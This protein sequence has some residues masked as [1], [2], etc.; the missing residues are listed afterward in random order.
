MV[1][2]RRQ[3]VNEAE[4]TPQF[5]KI[6]LSPH[7]SKL[8]IPDEFVMKYG[9]NMR[10]LVALEVPSGAIWK[11]KLQNSNGMAWL[12]EGWDQFKE[13]YSIGCGYF[14]LFQYNGISHFSVS[15]F[16]LSASEIEYP[17]G[18][19][20]DMTPENFVKIVGDASHRKKEGG[21]ETNNNACDDI[22]DD[23]LRKKTAKVTKVADHSYS[24]RQKSSV[25]EWQDR[26][27]VSL[28]KPHVEEDLYCATEKE[29]RKEIK[30]EKLE[31]QNMEK[32]LYHAA[33]KG[34]AEHCKEALDPP[35]S[36]MT[37]TCRCNKRKYS[38]SLEEPHCRH[39]LR[40]KSK[41]VEVVKLDQSK[42]E[43]TMHCV[44]PKNTVVADSSHSGRQKTA[45][46]ISCPET[47]DPKKVKLEKVNSEE[48]FHCAAPKARRGETNIEKL[49]KQDVQQN[50]YAEAY[51]FKEHCDEVP[52]V[53]PSASKMTTTNQQS[54][55][56]ITTNLD[57]SCCRYP[58]RSKQLKEVKLEK[59]DTEEDL[60][61]A[62][63]KVKRK[64]TNRVEL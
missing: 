50:L 55:K 56:K 19:S 57:A 53:D 64:E 33:D 44:K 49:E 26:I 18:P 43:A 3:A 30:K 2:R 7:A 14:L 5:F 61:C 4:I 8:R 1:K 46:P 28:E 15:I 59:R 17:S 10:D 32:N 58:L 24:R 29:K 21:P 6:I 22:V 40:S 63:Q 52:V 11:I 23:F 20:E 39:P 45:A 35:A 62:A 31:K 25:T 16:D 60:F 47:K 51:K 9:A 48:D 42:T 37:N 27:R 38:T 36:K 34:K 13:Y 41:P 54:E 12:K